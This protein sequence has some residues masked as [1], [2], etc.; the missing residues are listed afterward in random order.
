[1]GSPGRGALDAAGGFAGRV[2]VGQD[3]GFGVRVRVEQDR[4]F[5]VRV[6]VEQDRGFAVRVRGGQDRGFAVRVRVGQDRGFAVRVRVGQ[7]RGFAVRV[8]VGQ[9]RGFALTSSSRRLRWGFAPYPARGAPAPRARSHTD[10]GEAG[11]ASI[12]SRTLSFSGRASAAVG[13][14]PQ[15]IAY[16]RARAVPRGHGS[17][18]REGQPL[19]N[20]TQSK[21]ARCRRAWDPA[22]RAG[23]ELGPASRRAE[24]IPCSR[25]GAGSSRPSRGVVRAGERGRGPARRQVQ[26]VVQPLHASTSDAALAMRAF[27]SH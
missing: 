17:A 22:P 18:Q 6:R 9:D 11:P 16:R 4:G 19:G 7:D 20:E 5:G 15:P 23:A 3:R 25:S 1:V 2:R 21:G 26:A 13:P 14:R 27:A 12:A 10:S 24:W 8:R